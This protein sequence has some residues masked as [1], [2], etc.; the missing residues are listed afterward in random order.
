MNIGDYAGAQNYFHLATL[1]DVGLARAHLSMAEALL[2]TGRFQRGWQE[3]TWRS[4]LNGP[5]GAIQAMPGPPWSGEPLPEVGSSS[6]AMKA[7]AI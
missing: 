7:M 6:S 1:N 4:F 2:A 3:Y 5:S